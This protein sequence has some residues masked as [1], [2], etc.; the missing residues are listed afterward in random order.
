MKGYGT[1]PG[2]LNDLGAITGYYLDANGVYHG[3]L[4][5]P[6][7]NFTAPLDAPGADLTPGNFNGTFP[8]MINLFGEITGSA[9]DVNGANHGFVRSPNGTFKTVD[10]PGAGTGAFEGTVPVAHNLFGAIAGYYVDSND[11]ASA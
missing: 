7:G 5:S 1:F 10:A 4:R 9:S 11:V 8:S 2:S 3:F 6:D